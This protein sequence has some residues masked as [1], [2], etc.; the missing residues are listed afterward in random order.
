MRVWDHPLAI[1]AAGVVLI[2]G[3]VYFRM[4]SLRSRSWPVVSG[5][6]T[7][8]H[9]TYSGTGT[10]RTSSG[11]Y[12]AYRYGVGGKFYNGSV[13]SYAPDI[14]ESATSTVNRY[15]QGADVQVHYD[16][17]DPATAVLEPG[18]GLTPFFALIGGVGCFG[19]AFW[20]DRMA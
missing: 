9:L 11:S 4:L 18:T 6:I 19:Y 20:K 2:V 1:V 13:V 17:R 14:F 7:E 8:S 12:I 3:G 10:K 15:P 16:P 5:V